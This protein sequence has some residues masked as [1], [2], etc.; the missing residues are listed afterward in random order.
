MAQTRRVAPSALIEALEQNPRSFSFFEA[1]DLIEAQRP[2]CAQV[3]YRG[4]VAAEVVRFV[5]NT[6][7]SFPSADID[8]LVRQETDAG[9][10]YHMMVNFLGLYGQGTPLPL[11]YT[12][13]VLHA[14]LDEHA[15]K[16]FLDLFTHRLV[17]LFRRCGTKYRYYRAYRRDGSDPI[18]QWLFALMGVLHPSLRAGTSLDWQRLLAYAG[19][20][21]M[22]NHSAPMLRGVLSHYFP[23]APIAIE[24]FVP[25]LAA[26]AP[27]QWACLG[28][29]NCRLGEDLTIGIRVP[30][31]AGRIRVRIGRIGFARFQRFL[32]D[33]PDWRA[34]HD[35]VALLLRDQLRCDF[36]LVLAADEIPPLR[37]AQD[38]PC[39][40]GWSTWLGHS[41]ADGEVLFPG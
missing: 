40:L 34:A 9:S 15:V 23:G 30:D 38:S 22:R 6:S 33:G 11:W 7:L 5:G 27:E 31:C 13:D 20:I 8:G 4:P 36:Q 19:I 25:E 2:E 32:P 10:R 14:E 3:G 16:D 1:V 41:E 28:L 12:E 24:Q 29:D 18:S 37:L 26:I 35:L 39:R 17:S 21:A